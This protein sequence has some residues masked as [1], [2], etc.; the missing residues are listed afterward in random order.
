MPRP[1]PQAAAL[2]VRGGLVCLITSR[3]GKRWVVPKGLIDPGQTPATAAAAEAWEEAGLTGEL[4]AGPV[5]A[6]H[7][8][9]F[10]ADHEVSVFLLSVTGEAADWPERVARRREWVTPEEAARR[11]AE[12][13]LK[14][15]ILGSL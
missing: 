13:E 10:G 8:E 7:Y 6:Y 3:G 9:K 4:S 11:V 15:L 14:V 2:P 1:V 5:G 12:P